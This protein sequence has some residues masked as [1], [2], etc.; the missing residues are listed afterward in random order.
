MSRRIDRTAS[1]SRPAR[2]VGVEILRFTPTAMVNGSRP[3]R[4]V[5]VEIRTSSYWFRI[6]DVTSREGRGSRNWR[7]WSGKEETTVT[8]RE[9]RGSRNAKEVKLILNG[10]RVTSR[11]GRGSRNEL[12]EFQ[13]W[14][15]ERHVPRGAWE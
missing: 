11:E 5:G 15:S 3:A 10:Q 13:K 9:G 4:G 12:A 1:S 6:C 2:G 8:S 14:L 7:V